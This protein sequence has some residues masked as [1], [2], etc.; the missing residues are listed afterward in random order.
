MFPVQQ[1]IAA[2]YE[3]YA[4]YYA[5]GCWDQLSGLTSIVRLLQMGAIVCNSLA[6]VADLPGDWRKPTASGTLALFK[7]CNPFYDFLGSN[8]AAN[9]KSA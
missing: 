1:A 6:V 2:G 8:Q 5:S 7:E 9:K 4:V 3:V